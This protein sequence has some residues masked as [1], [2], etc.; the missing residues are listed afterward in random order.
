ML[1][2]LADKPNITWEKTMASKTGTTAP[3]KVTELLRL[4]AVTNKFRRIKRT[5]HYKGKDGYERNGEHVFQLTFVA[6][7]MQQRWFSHLDLLKVLLYCLAHD[8]PETYAGDTPAFLDP[9][10]DPDKNEN[11]HEDKEERERAAVERLDQEWGT[12]FPSLIMHMTGYEKRDKE[13][14]RFVYALDK[15]L[16]SLNIHEDEGRTNLLLKVTQAMEAAYKRS[17]IAEHPGV[18]ELYDAFCEFCKDKPEHYFQPEQ[19][20]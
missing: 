7:Y 16:A 5:I 3:E 20:S 9:S 13:E 18:L 17:R 6:W 8:I 2:L 12:E 4:V 1:Y 19:S 15:F 11:I 14:S 10:D